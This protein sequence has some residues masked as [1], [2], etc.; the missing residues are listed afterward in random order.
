MDTP[1]NNLSDVLKALDDKHNKVAKEIVDNIDKISRH[2]MEIIQDLI[3]RCG[4][5]EAIQFRLFSVL[6]E[7]NPLIH[8][9]IVEELKDNLKHIEDKGGAETLYANH[10]RELVEQSA[11][12]KVHL[13]LVPKKSSLDLPQQDP[14]TVE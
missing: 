14:S 10:V 13:R 3:Y 4:A 6:A 1:K 12:K 9:T 11:E 5:L 8:K 2:H 7:T